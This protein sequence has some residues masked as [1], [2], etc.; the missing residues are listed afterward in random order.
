MILLDT[1]IL[2]W[3]LD[4][5]AK[6]ST[7]QSQAIQG[8]PRLAVSAISLWEIA[9]LVENSRLELK[10]PVLDWINAALSHPKLQ[11]MALTPEIIVKSTQLPDTFHKDPADQLIVATAMVVG[12]PLLTKDLKILGYSHVTTIG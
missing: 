7:A 11:V 4:Q 2:I 6:L 12:I 3:L 9:K 8:A 10:M 5:Q 1:P